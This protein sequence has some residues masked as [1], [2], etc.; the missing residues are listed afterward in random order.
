MGGEAG[1]LSIVS[2]VRGSEDEAPAHPCAVLAAFKAADGREE[3]VAR[4]GEGQDRQ[5]L[6]ER[7]E[8]FLNARLNAASDS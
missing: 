6:G 2:V 3:T 1:V 8:N 4:K 5:S 7:P